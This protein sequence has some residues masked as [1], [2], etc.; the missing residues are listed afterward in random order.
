MIKKFFALD[1]N[2]D[3]MIQ[4]ALPGQEINSVMP[5]STGWTNIVYEVN[6][7]NG[8]YFFRFPRDDFW[9]RTIVKDCQFANFIHGK[10]DFNTADLKLN[11]NNSRPFSVHKKLRRYLLNYLNLCI[12]YIM[13]NL[14]KIKC[15]QQMILA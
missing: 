11:Y 14:T 15:F 12:S 4:D 1:E 13:L 10:T 7:N 5:V 9:I 8:N 6:T 2:F 3:K